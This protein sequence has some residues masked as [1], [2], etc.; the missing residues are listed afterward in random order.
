MAKEVTTK[1]L[2]EDTRIKRL[3]DILKKRKLISDKEAKEI[4]VL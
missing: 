3:V 1:D 4:M 2:L